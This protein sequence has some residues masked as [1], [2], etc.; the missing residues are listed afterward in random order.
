MWNGEMFMITRRNFFAGTAVLA[1]AGCAH[2]KLLRAGPSARDYSVESVD[3]GV[4]PDAIFNLMSLDGLSNAEQG[5][6][7]KREVKQATSVRVLQRPGGPRKAH[8]EIVLRIVDV[9][10]A[11]GRVLSVSDSVIRADVR[12]V[13]AK[14]KEIVA[15]QPNLEAIDKPM[16]GDG[17]I[18]L[19]VSLVVNA[20]SADQTYRKV[21]TVFADKVREWLVD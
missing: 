13:D 17:N 7:I 3:V 5:E 8:L 11:A 19:V 12:L 2:D 16:R 18:G 21:A 15:F 14:T 10:S 1:L 4:A 9:S 6:M 20:A